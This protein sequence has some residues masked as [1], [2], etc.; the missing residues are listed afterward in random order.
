MVYDVLNDIS[1]KREKTQ[2]IAI[3]DTKLLY[4]FTEAILKRGKLHQYTLVFLANSRNI[5]Q[6]LI[7]HNENLFSIKLEH[8]Q[9]ASRH[10]FTL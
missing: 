2:I 4:S 5:A 3:P 6:N 7:N 8:F 1:R 10:G 9:N